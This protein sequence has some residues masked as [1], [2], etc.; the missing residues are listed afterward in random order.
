MKK[1][2]YI[3]KKT[4]LATEKIL[5]FIIPWKLINGRVQISSEGKRGGREKMAKLIS[6]PPPPSI[7]GTSIEALTQIRL[8]PIKPGLF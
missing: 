3:N 1:K 7:L 4:H 2:Y 5:Y 6:V 8:N